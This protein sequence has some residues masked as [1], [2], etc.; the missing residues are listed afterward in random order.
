MEGNAEMN[1]L[2]FVVYNIIFSV[3]WVGPIYIFTSILENY[4]FEKDI[5]KYLMM[6]YTL[7]IF[8]IFPTKVYK[9]F[10]IKEK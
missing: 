2:K 1:I 8:I 6:I 7:I 5:I 9:L 10:N 4:Y 3:V